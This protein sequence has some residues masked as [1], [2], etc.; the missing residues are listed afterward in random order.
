MSEG[1][2]QQCNAKTNAGNRCKRASTAKGNNIYCTQHFNK[3]GDGP[4]PTEATTTDV[5]IA[6]Q[7]ASADL[8]KKTVKVPMKR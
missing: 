7:S 6:S 1:V 8:T 3:A 5:S 2:V 4:D